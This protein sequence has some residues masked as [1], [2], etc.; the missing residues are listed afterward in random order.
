MAGRPLTTV[1]I[2]EDDAKI[3]S[4]IAATLEH[5]GL[6]A[7]ECA[8]LAEARRAAMQAFPDVV[9]TDL[10][11]ADGKAMELI[12][13]LRARNP[14]VRVT[15]MSGFNES[16]VRDNEWIAAEDA[17]LAKPFDISQML[18]LLAIQPQAA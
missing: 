8:S 12:T 17:F 7:T 14:R 18:R 9:L 11:L 3:R 5:Y 10:I 4:F 6:L 13:W 15:F 1:L 16:S 2:I